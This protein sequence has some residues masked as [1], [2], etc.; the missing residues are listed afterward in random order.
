M[1]K[2]DAPHATPNN[3]FTDGNPST[4]IEATELIAKWH[5]TVQREIVNVI[6]GAGLTL[7]D[8]NDGQL[9]ASIQAL[10]RTSGAIF[11]PLA[12]SVGA[13]GDYATLN[14][15]LV[16]ISRFRPV[17]GIPSIRAT[18]TL[19]TGFVMAEQIICD[20]VDLSWITITSV[21][22]VVPVTETAITHVAGPVDY[23]FAVITP[24]IAAI[25]GGKSPYINVVFRYDTRLT[26]GRTGLFAAG[27]GSVINGFHTGCQNAHEYGCFVFGGGQISA[28][29]L[30]NSDAYLYGTY[31]KGAG[32]VIVSG[33]IYNLNCAHAGCVAVDNALISSVGPGKIINNTGCTYHGCVVATG[34]TI[35]SENYINNSG[36]GTRG[37]QAVSGGRIMAK[38]TID[39][40]GGGSN[41]AL[42]ETG[43]VVI[44][45]TMNNRRGASDDITD[46]LVLLGGM[47]I[48]VSGNGGLSQA[49]GTMTADGYINV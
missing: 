23:G 49:A 32:S 14:D 44:A 25:K 40:S 47:I 6:E 24:V 42:A 45:G 18:I 46:T 41:G 1:H 21:D 33:S 36:C 3:E 15:A 5:N 29:S 19:L 8:A 9:F 26:E 17:Y 38:M 13:G 39:N 16:H 35:S 4:G 27:A 10:L 37:A 43:G 11:T 2:I 28:D 7:N 20:G 30:S 31:A 22:G 48:R 34:G 12:V